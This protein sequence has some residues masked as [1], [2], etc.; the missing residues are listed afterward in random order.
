VRGISGAGKSAVDCLSSKDADIPSATKKPPVEGWLFLEIN[1]GD[2]LISHTQKCS[3]IG[4][5]R[6]YFRVRDG[7]G[8]CPR[9]IVTG[10]LRKSSRRR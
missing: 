9:S 4:P 10:K 3:T 8:C 2:H 6:L 1:A 5:A 7:N